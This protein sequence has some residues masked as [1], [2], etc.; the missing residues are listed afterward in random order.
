MAEFIEHL[1][2]L[3]VPIVEGPE[4]RTGAIGPIMSVYIRDPDANLIEICNYER[5]EGLMVP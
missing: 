5:R 2:A 3:K 1:K 4:S